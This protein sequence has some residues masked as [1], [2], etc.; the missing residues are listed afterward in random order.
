VFVASDSPPAVEWGGD[1]AAERSGGSTREC[2]PRPVSWF[3]LG[4]PKS[5]GAQV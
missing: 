3:R 4:F 1:G 2:R 5:R